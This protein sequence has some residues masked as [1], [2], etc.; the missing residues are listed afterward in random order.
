MHATLTKGALVFMASDVM[1][2]TPLEQGNNMWLSLNIASLEEI[3]TLFAAF[4]VSGQIILPLQQT[5]WAS[6]FG[7]LK[8]QFGI[9]WMFNLEPPR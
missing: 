2:G 5:F 9:H 6:R 7:M 4:S 1:P 3:D 8:D